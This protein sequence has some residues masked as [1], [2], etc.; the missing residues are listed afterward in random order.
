MDWDIIRSITSIGWFRSVTIKDAALL[1]TR[2][3]L[4]AVVS[5]AVANA[6]AISAAIVNAVVVSTAIV[7]AAAVL[8]SVR[9]KQVKDGEGTRAFLYTKK[10]II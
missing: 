3:S 1:L 7:N 9:S 2:L 6:V 5:A 4:A 8:A 10:S